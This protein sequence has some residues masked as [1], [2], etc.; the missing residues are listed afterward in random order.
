MHRYLIALAKNHPICSACI[1]GFLVAFGVWIALALTAAP[2]RVPGQGIGSEDPGD[3][4]AWVGWGPLHLATQSPVQQLRLAYL[5][6]SPELHAPRTWSLVT[7]LNWANV[8]VYDA[9][10][11]RMDEE[12]WVLS[13]AVEY[14]FDD[15]LAA[16]LMAP[17]RYRNGGVMDGTIERFHGLI[18]LGNAG[19]E[20]YPRGDLRVDAIREDG[21]VLTLADER[22]TGWLGGAPVLSLRWGLTGPRARAPLTLKASLDVPAL[23]GRTRVVRRR[24]HD[25]AVGLATAGRLSQRVA[26]TVSL[27]VVQ[28]RRGGLF[29]EGDLS[30]RQLSV[31]LAADYGI[32]EA[33]G[34]V[35]QVLSESPV[36]DRTGTGFDEPATDLA[37]GLKWQLDRDLQLEFAMVENLFVHDNNADFALHGALRARFK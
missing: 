6:E 9:Q 34:L 14:T 25:W 3:S 5:H 1:C 29:H 19:R 7:S 20:R 28:S 8:W 36:G 21:T 31:M 22:D 35:G 15:R 10:R 12:V 17:F 27:A 13:Q 16:S 33:W 32:S 23:E 24:G 18:G 37:L 2:Q 4:P 11:L 26:G 30:T